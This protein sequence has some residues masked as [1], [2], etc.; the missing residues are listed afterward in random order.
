MRITEWTSVRKWRSGAGRVETE[1]NVFRIFAKF[2]AKFIC[3]F[4]RNL[5]AK[6]TKKLVKILEKVPQKLRKVEFSLSSVE[7]RESLSATCETK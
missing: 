2:F 7:K 6:S 5:L 4:L 1:V 3:A